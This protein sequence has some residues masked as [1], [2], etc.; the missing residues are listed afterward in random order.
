MTEDS[1][2]IN[3]QKRLRKRNDIGENVG[4]YGRGACKILHKS[5]GYIG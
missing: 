3:R 4:I 1:T 2:M 5:L